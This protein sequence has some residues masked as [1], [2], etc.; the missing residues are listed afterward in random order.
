MCLRVSPFAVV[1]RVSIEVVTQ[2]EVGVRV[3]IGFV[4]QRQVGAA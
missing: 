4:T 1:V 3:L 2:C